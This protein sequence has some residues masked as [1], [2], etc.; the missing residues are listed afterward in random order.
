M[1]WIAAG[2]TILLCVLLNTCFVNAAETAIAWITTPSGNVKVVKV[3]G[4]E[5]AAAKD[6]PLYPGDM[7]VTGE[8]GRVEFTFKR[9]DVF[10]LYEDSQ[11]SLDE[12]SLQ[13]EEAQPALRLT[14][15]HLWTRIMASVTKPFKPSFH[16][17]TAVL[18]IRG[19][20]FE[21]VVSMDTASAVAVDEGAVS[22][23]TETASVVVAAGKATE[24]EADDTIVRPFTALPPKKRNW[25]KWRAKRQQK[26]IK[27]L[28]EKIP[29]IR[30]RF[31]TAAGRYIQLAERVKAAAGQLDAEIETAKA[32]IARRDRRQARKSIRKINT[33]EKRFRKK[34]A[35][36]RKG[37]NRLRVVGRH[38]V[39]LEKFVNNNL[40]RLPPDK[41]RTVQNELGA[42]RQ[43]RGQLKQ[44]VA[45]A[46]RTVREMGRKLRTFRQ[47]LKKQGRAQ[48]RKRRQ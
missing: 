9:G 45:E 44:S 42:M 40:D 8:D 16:T 37:M 18:G 48:K 46:I 24:I 19:T 22:V 5:H 27:H 31:E 39:R 14:L 35:G 32:A 15:G 10:N 26:L 34:A 7:L 29:L 17:P 47:D 21:T 28:P 33:I 36:F 41:V 43:Q 20:E 4:S 25:R 12:L 30:R 1:S 11:V 23:E 6:L 38:S 2:L 3:D 13:E